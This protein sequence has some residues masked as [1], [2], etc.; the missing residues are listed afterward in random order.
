M[1]DLSLPPPDDDPAR[2]PAR[3]SYD[4]FL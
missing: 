1:P 4:E 3:Q 2:T